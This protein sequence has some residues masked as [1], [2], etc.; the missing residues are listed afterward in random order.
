MAADATGQ[1]M[2]A[3]REAGVVQSDDAYARGVLYLL[4]TQ[5]ADGSWCVRTRALPV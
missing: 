4:S 5:L 1:P 3:R 2:S